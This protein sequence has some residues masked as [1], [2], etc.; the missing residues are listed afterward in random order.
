MITPMVAVRATAEK[1]I[2]VLYYL[3]YIYNMLYAGMNMML[4]DVIYD[5]I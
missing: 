4:Y 5:V 1:R 3:H 2:I